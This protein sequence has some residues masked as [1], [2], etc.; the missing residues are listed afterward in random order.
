MLQKNN[1]DKLGEMNNIIN[2]IKQRIENGSN[3][4]DNEVQMR[5][6]FQ[7]FA[8]ALADTT[9]IF[10]KNAAGG[11]LDL[12]GV[13][14]AATTNMGLAIGNKTKHFFDQLG[15]PEPVSTVIGKGASILPDRLTKAAIESI[16]KFI[17]VL[18]KAGWLDSIA[19]IFVQTFADES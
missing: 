10:A 5:G 4:I 13:T 19:D 6:L 16:A 12:I 11:V 2:R 15:I 9:V 17:P 14:N 1:L 18:E 8:Q 7:D 3:S